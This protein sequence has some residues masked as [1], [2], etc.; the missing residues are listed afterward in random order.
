MIPRLRFFCLVFLCLSLASSLSS[1]PLFLSS[2]PLSLPCLACFRSRFFANSVSSP[3]LCQF[4]FCFSFFA[5][6]FSSLSFFFSF[7][8]PFVVALFFFFFVHLL[9]IFLLAYLDSV[10]LADRSERC[11]SIKLL[12]IPFSR[13]GG[14]KEPAHGSVFTPLFPRF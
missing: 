5:S 6:S 13:T 7:W 9:F 4:L 1:S 10:D 3:F 11:S 14:G 2:L 12:S 8:F